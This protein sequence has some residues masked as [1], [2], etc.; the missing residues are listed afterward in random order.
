MYIVQTN[1]SKFSTEK[2]SNL[3]SGLIISNAKNI[4]G[5]YAL[6]TSNEKLK[7]IILKLVHGMT[8]GERRRFLKLCDEYCSEGLMGVD[9]NGKLLAKAELIRINAPY[10][11][12]FSK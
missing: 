2:L 11:L 10:S 3:L 12:E 4:E 5:N 9:D 1:V 6:L 8:Q 7:R